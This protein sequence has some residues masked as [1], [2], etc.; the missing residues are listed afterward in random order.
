MMSA[1]WLIFTALFLALGIFHWITSRKAI[2]PFKVSTRPFAEHGSV[3]VLGADID[4]PLKDFTHDF[5][6]YLEKYNRLSCRQNRLQALGYLLAS[7]TALSSFFLF[8]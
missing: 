8:L 2:S 7:L 3:Q 4:K 1:I 5:N 6:S